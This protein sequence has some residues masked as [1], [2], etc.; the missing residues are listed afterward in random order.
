MHQVS[1]QFVT[2]AHR[3]SRIPYVDIIVSSLGLLFLVFSYFE[4]IKDQLLDTNE[5]RLTASLLE[6]SKLKIDLYS[7]GLSI[8]CP[9]KVRQ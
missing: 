8:I 2:N 9:A 6:C 3:L 5:I 4:R 1:E 7:R